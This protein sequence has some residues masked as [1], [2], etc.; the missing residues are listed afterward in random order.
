MAVVMQDKF[1]RLGA[2]LEGELVERTEEIR[3]ALLALVA[4]CTFFM[5]GPPGVAKSLLAR[6]IAARLSDVRFFDVG[7]DKFS[8][9]EVLYG[10]HDL[11]ALK[12]GRWERVLDGT[13]VTADFAHID[14]IFEASS[15]LLK[16]MLWALNERI[17]R[18]GTTVIPM[19]LSTVFMSSNSV[20]TE[21]RLAALWDRL[22]LRRAL[23]PVQEAKSFAAMLRLDLDDKPEP[24]LSWVEVLQAQAEA[25]AV[26]LP[27]MV[28]KVVWELRRE[29]AKKK[30]HPSDRRFVEGMGVVRAAAW[31][32]GR[33][34][35]TPGDL[36][37]LS[38]VLWQF[39]EEVTLVRQVVNRVLDSH[40]DPATRLLH[41]VR[42]I[43]AQVRDGLPERERLELA[44][45]LGGKVRAARR[46]LETLE[47]A[48]KTFGTE[49][50]RGLLADL[51]DEILEKL[52]DGDVA[53]LDAPPHRRPTA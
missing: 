17:Y 1:V 21:P 27:E 35:A 9:P 19:P 14:E 15:A 6:R 25:A 13:L 4:G 37:C 38:D 18:Q 16:S 33:Q 12:A 40:I 5:V 26:E 30:V 49:R 3:C 41:D 32:D 23:Q 10:P 11:K 44:E 24:V 42:A 29:L 50:V 20:P 52:F 39:P 46:E 8:T 47:R 36:T 48:G 2:E 51:A 45:E 7:L 22:V 31:L 34:E 43:K 28:T 53:K